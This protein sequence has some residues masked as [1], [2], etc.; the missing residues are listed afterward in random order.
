MNHNISMKKL[1]RETS[2]RMAMLRNLTISLVR[3]KQINTTL[4]R[5]KALRPFVEPLVTLASRKPDLLS[6][7]RRLFDKIRDKETVELLLRQVG[8]HY[9]KRPGG[10]TRVIKNGFRPGDSSPMAVIQFVDVESMLADKKTKATTEKKSVKAA[11]KQDKAVKKVDGVV[12]DAP[13]KS[14]S[15]S[16][17][18]TEVA[19]KAAPQ[20]KTTKAPAKKA[21]KPAKEGK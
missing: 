18:K 5:A 12:S 14:T 15:A 1:S 8:P 4:S 11:S 13:K 2:H 19:K 7:R 10:Y 17:K 3:H 21:T 20:K 16:K 6:T 9:T